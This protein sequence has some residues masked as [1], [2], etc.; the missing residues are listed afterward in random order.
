MRI[1]NS[2]TLQVNG[3]GD[4][5]CL[6]QDDY[7]DYPGLVSDTLILFKQPLRIDLG[8]KSKPTIGIS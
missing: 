5:L 3:E 7:G 1:T 4:G 8:G 2:L 6:Y